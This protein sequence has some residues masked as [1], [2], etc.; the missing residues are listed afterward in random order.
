VAR[1]EGGDRIVRVEGVVGSNH[2]DMGYRGVDLLD[3]GE[4]TDTCQDQH[5]VR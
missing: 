3:G 4:D 1:G 2:N 5:G